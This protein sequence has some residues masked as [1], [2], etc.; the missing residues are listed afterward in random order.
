[1][2]RCTLLCLKWITSKDLLD[3]TWNSAQLPG[4][5]NGRGVWRRMDTCTPVAESLHH[6]PEAIVTLFVSRLVLC[7]LVLSQWCP[8]LCSPMDY[9][10]PGSSVHGIF[11]ARILV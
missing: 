7:S 10:L 3:S 6:S 2:D 1:M 8:T 4:S 11:Q 5:L 9:S